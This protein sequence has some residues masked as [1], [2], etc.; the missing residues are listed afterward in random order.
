MRILT[1][2]ELSNT[3]RKLAELERLYNINEQESDGD[4]EL[5]EM[6]IESLT[7]LIN[8]L[9]EEIR[10]SEIGHRAREASARA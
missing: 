6:T 1:E 7:R 10:R 9:K 5:R 2:V 4:E 8:Q 3:R